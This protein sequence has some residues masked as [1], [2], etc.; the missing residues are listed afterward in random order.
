[1]TPPVP[2]ADRGMRATEI[3]RDTSVVRTDTRG[4]RR[5]RDA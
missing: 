3:P 2:S 1:M 4:A 5:G